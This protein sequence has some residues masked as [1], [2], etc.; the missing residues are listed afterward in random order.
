MKNKFLKYTAFVVLYIAVLMG[1]IWVFNHINPW[2]GILTAI[3]TLA[4]GVQ[5]SINKFK[6]GE[7]K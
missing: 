2:V 4:G 5:F 1:C 3:F 7:T 6:K